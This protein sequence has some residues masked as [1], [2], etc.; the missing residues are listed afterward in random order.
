MLQL[1]SVSCAAFVTQDNSATYPATETQEKLTQLQPALLKQPPSQ[2]N[3]GNG[4]NVDIHGFTSSGL[5]LSALAK[6][7][8]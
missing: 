4:E 1:T 8:A 5:T 6:N 2:K 3:L 7:E